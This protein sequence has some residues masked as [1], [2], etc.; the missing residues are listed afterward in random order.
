MISKWYLTIPLIAA[1]AVF[2]GCRS[3]KPET[4]EPT[5]PEPNVSASGTA[6]P[7]NTT[8]ATHYATIELDGGA[9]IYMELYGNAAP[10]TVDNFVKL[11]KK[12]FYDTLTFHRVE[13]GFVIQGGDPNG[14]GTGGPGY[15][16]KFEKNSL[17]HKTGSLAMARAQAFD[18]AGSQ[19]YI[20][21]GPQPALDGK[22]CVFG[23]VIKGMDAVMKV[24][25]DDIISRVTISETN[26]LEPAAPKSG[27]ASGQPEQS[28]P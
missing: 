6:T 21:L 24:K 27:E 18:S 25:K 17:K 28:K 5:V 15:M 20:C 14:D 11:T 9:K 4:K 7:D 3:N 16:I 1:V 10:K 13:P 22:Y 2:A 12:F 23:Q 26:P 8:K 19:F